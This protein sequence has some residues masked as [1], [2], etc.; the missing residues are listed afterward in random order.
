MS[1]RADYLA[2]VVGNIHRIKDLSEKQTYNIIG[3]RKRQIKRIHREL[4]LLY[5]RRAEFRNEEVEEGKARR[6]IAE[7]IGIKKENNEASERLQ[8]IILMALEQLDEAEPNTELVKAILS[9]AKE[10]YA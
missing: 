3:Q 10:M 6:K 9:Q 7:Y 1:F 4:R 2:D 8:A 5:E